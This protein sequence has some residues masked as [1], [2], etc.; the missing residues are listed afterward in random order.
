MN[1]FKLVGQTLTAGG[2]LIT[3]SLLFAV[4]ASDLGIKTAKSSQT[5]LD[6]AFAGVAWKEETRTAKA[7]E[8][9]EKAEAAKRKKAA[10]KA[11]KT[12]ASNAAAAAA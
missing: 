4:G 12:R 11:A 2:K 5:N 3:S 10:K 9:A 6:A 1:T 7:K 8:D